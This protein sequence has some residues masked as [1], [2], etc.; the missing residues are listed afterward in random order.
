MSSKP[1][2]PAQSQRGL[3]RSRSPENIH[4]A[5]PDDDADNGK[6]L[7]NPPGLRS[8]LETLPNESHCRPQAS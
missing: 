6:L 3:K 4:G 5:S 8:H 7:L 2:T 1:L